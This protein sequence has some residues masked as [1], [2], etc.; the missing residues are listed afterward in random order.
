MGN[1][2][3]Q[4]QIQQ[5]QLLPQKKWLRIPSQCG[6][7]TSYAEGWT[8]ESFQKFA[9][10]Q[11]G[12]DQLCS[13]MF[14]RALI[15]RGM[16]IQ[17]QKNGRF[18]GCTFCNLENPFSFCVM[19]PNQEYKYTHVMICIPRNEKES[20]FIELYRKHGNQAG[21]S[22]YYFG[23]HLNEPDMRKYYTTTNELVNGIEHYANLNNNMK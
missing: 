7:M 12:S 23:I 8:Y 17:A 9:M 22:Q 2:F 3:A 13:E 4:N 14:E 15:V 10:K 5:N 1:I 19:L 16:L 20:C 6:L 11:L 18:I 21:G